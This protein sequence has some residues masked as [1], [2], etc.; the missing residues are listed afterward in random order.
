MLVGGICERVVPVSPY[1]AG[2]GVD[3]VG[4]LGFFGV[5]FCFVFFSFVGSGFRLLFFFL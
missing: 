2:F 4:G 1:K 5:A 3:G